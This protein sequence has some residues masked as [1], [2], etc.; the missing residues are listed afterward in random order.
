MLTRF[1]FYGIINIS[2]VLKLQFLNDFRALY[3]IYEG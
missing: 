2:V 3:P 1:F